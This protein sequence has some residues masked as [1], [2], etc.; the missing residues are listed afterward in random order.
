MPTTACN[1][2]SQPI[3]V[4]CSAL[5]EQSW[6]A[7]CKTAA[8]Q[9]RNGCG[10]SY[11]YYVDRFSAAIDTHIDQLP[12]CQRA[13]ALQKAEEEWGYATPAKR[14]ETQNWNAE[15]GYCAH[16]IELG[17]CPAGCGS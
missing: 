14:Q 13:Q 9:A 3:G 8:T 6:L 10:L 2:P 5:D 12:E 7:I 15:H 4:T 17:Y 16:G 11:D 1:T